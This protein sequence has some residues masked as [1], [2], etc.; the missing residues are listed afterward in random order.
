VLTLRVGQLIRQ[1]RE[2]VEPNGTM[3]AAVLFLL[4]TTAATVSAPHRQQRPAPAPAAG[5]A[6]STQQPASTNVDALTL[7]PTSGALPLRGPA[8][9]ATSGVLLQLA[10]RP[11]SC[12]AI[13]SSKHDD[14]CAGHGCIVQ[15][16]CASAPKWRTAAAPGGNGVLIQTGGGSGGVAA[17]LPR[18]ESGHHAPI[19]LDLNQGITRVQAYDCGASAAYINQHWEV[20]GGTTAENFTIRTT[21][22]KYASQ[23]AICVRSE[24]PP[25]PP[26]PPAPPPPKPPAVTP[27]ACPKYH[28]GKGQYDPSGVIQQPDGVWHM[29]PDGGHWSHCTSRDLLHWDCSSHPKSTGFDGD[30]G[31][32]TVTPKG[33]F[34]MWPAQGIEMAT[35]TDSSLNTWVKH[36]TVGTGGQRDPGRA[37][38]LKSGWFVPEG[39][40]GIHWF[41]DESGGAMTKLNH[42]GTMMDMHTAGLTEFECPDVFELAGKIVVLTSTQGLNGWT[43]FWVGQMSDD[44]LKFLPDYTG[45]LDYGASG[46]STIYAAKTGTSALPPFD[47]RVL[48]GFG[49][50]TESKVTQCSNWYL[51]PKDLSLS[52]RGRLLQHP[53]REMIGLRKS[54]AKFPVLAAG[55]QVEILVQCAIP[56][57]AP[58]AG[59]LGVHTL[60]ASNQSILSGYNFSAGGPDD[61]V[62]GFADVPASLST[63]GARTDRVSLPA[64]SNVTTLEL[65]IFVDGHMVETFFGG[66]AVISTI[67]SNAVSTEKISSSFVNTAGLKCSDISSWTLSL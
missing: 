58:S 67:T 49:G 56:K 46:I 16:P 43:Q 25:P 24:P 36:G 12:L 63:R 26:K 66:H 45:R 13:D 19:C 55:S 40:N 7:C 14:G 62:G 31:S 15:A 9:T 22:Q 48:L 47:R 6:H 33:T 5:A 35:P 38:Q 54:S 1:V 60:V 11:G 51:L 64:L 18:S 27:D 21:M 23:P 39:V 50:W 10:G 20:A 3:T 52:S 44:D 41:R 30:T 2:M 37:I 53:A 28:A 42:T 57:P 61:W 4:L 32:I 59:V 17:D 29:F 34:A 65:R 8:P